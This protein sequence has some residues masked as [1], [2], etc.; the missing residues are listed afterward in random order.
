MLARVSSA[1]NI[2]LNCCFPPVRHPPSAIAS[3]PSS[4]GECDNT[5]STDALIVCFKTPIYCNLSNK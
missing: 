5:R 1:G 3:F 2:S 4:A